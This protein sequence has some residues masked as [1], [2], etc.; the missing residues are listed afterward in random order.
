MSELEFKV[1]PVYES[2]T[3]KY[4]IYGRLH[5]IDPPVTTVAKCLEFE[6]VHVGCRTKPFTKLTHRNAVSLMDQ[7]YACG[8][9]PT[10]DD[11]DINEEISDEVSFLK[12]ILRRQ[13]IHLG[14]LRNILELR[15][16]PFLNAGELY[17][18]LMK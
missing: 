10:E 12:E 9:R 14:D 2:N 15:N 7:L 8:I 3:T 18:N 6:K 5:K 13:D 11:K 4:N 16:E 17:S 1:E